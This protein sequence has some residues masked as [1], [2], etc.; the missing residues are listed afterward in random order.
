MQAL[1][2]ICAFLAFVSLPAWALPP[3]VVAAVQAPA[4][5]ERGGL[6]QPL[7][8]GMPLANG[9]RIRTGDGA[10]AYL[11]LAEGSTVKLGADAKLAF[12]SMSAKPRSE[13]RGALDVLNGA[14]RF[15]TDALMRITSRDIAIRVGTA[16]AGIRGTDLWGRADVRQDLV[17]LIEGKIDVWHAAL[18]GPVAMSAPLSV[19]VAA[20]GEAPRPLVMADTQEFG[21]WARETEIA[22]G[23]GAAR[24]GGKWKLSLGRHAIE[25]EAL[26]QYDVARSAGYAVGIKPSAAAGG[27]WN[28]EVILLGFPDAAEAAAA[29]ARL[30]AATGI[31]ATAAR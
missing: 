11:K 17:C 27:G 26:T 29:A 13:F 6:V 31:A 1:K 8:V 14:F 5:I 16:T 22:P 10:R 12:F 21:R 4:W 24:T 18:P 15:T 7:A 9:D 30:K 3:A 2:R 28:Y 19:F 23:D 25:A 20:R